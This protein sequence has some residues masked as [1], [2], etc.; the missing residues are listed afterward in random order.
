MPKPMPVPVLS[1]S[2]Y[3]VL[4]VV[5]LKKMTTTAA[6]VAATGLPEDQV[7]ASLSELEGRGLVV[8]AGGSAFP[9]D[10]AE[11]ALAASAAEHY[12]QVR[13]DQEVISL[14]DRFEDINRQLLASMSAWQQVEVGGQKVANDHTDSRYDDRVIERIGRLVQRLGPLLDALAR[15][16]GRFTGY[17]R[18]FDAALAGIDEGRHELVSYPSLDS[19]HTIWFEFHEDL[20][21]TIG[22]ARKE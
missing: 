18:R 7:A 16:D 17:R 12:D 19:V 5:A 13:A 9:G 8:T 1:K 14:V 4:N 11:D 22:R 15:F 2:D 20:L 3:G 21:R 6:V 10:G